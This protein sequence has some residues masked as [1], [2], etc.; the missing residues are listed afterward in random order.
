ML[1]GE[2]QRSSKAKHLSPAIAVI[3]SLLRGTGQVM[4]QNNPITGL[5][6][7]VGICINSYKGGS[8]ALLGLVVA[9]LAAHLLGA[10]HTLIHNGLFG[11]NGVLDRHR[12]IRLSPVGLAGRGLY[13]PGCDHLNDRDA[14]RQ[15]Q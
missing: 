4:F 12:V 8:T 11:F 13:H 15:T 6:L 7:P 1:R 5:P 2:S 9:T 14:V 10:E 3:D